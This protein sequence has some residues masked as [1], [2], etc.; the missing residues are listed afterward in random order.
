MFNMNKRKIIVSIAL[1][2]FLIPGSA[3]A[4]MLRDS[5]VASS[6][7][8][9]GNVTISSITIS[10]LTV[11]HSISVSSGF[12]AFSGRVIQSTYASISSQVQAT[13]TVA[14]TGISGLARTISL[15]NSAN[16]VRISLSGCLIADNSSANSGFISIFRDSNNLGDANSGLSKVAGR[17]SPLKSVGIKMIDYPGDT[18]PHTYQVYIRTAEWPF[19]SAF[20]WESIGYLLVEE[21]GQ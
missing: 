2:T 4:L 21:I 6:V 11:T 13:S 12:P 1:A 16:Y 10:T 20:P 17:Y 9:S 18:N 3:K 14:W 19:F 5:I 15:S 8:V 7:S